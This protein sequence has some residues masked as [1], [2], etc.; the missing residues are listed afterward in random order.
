MAEN[1]VQI[2]CVTTSVFTVL[3]AVFTTAFNGFL[4]YV[5]YKD[6]INRLRKPVTSFMTAIAVM[7]LLTGLIC[8][9]S[10]ARFEIRCA[11]KM[12][13][14]TQFVLGG[15]TAVAAFFTINSATLLILAMSTERLIAVGWPHF[16]RQAV[17]RK[18]FG[19]LAIGVCIYCFVYSILQLTKVDSITW[20][21][22]D[23]Y[24][25]TVVP[26]VTVIVIYIAISF[27]LRSQRKKLFN[28]KGGRSGQ[29]TNRINKL[30]AERKIVFTA[31]LITL[32]LLLA[33]LPYIVM[34]II[35][36]YCESCQSTKWFVFISRIAIPFAFANS[37]AN[38]CV[39]ISCM[40]DVQ[41]SVKMILNRTFRRDPNA[42]GIGG[43]IRV[44]TNSEEGEQSSKT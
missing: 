10:Q 41:R 34:I 36:R 1:F 9:T 25:H 39:Y 40:R 35:A 27:M 31:F 20:Q 8:D 42:V 4:L 32:L 6:P 26:I 44:T 23:L 28:G 22:V 16:Y 43:Q 17:T 30:K 12:D 5:I 2:V 37:V 21:K 14:E 7:D 29:N 15:F 13:T 33:F 18:R 38:P 19:V 24:L 3:L 11:L